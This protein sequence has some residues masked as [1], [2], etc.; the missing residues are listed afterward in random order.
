MIEYVEDKVAEARLVEG[1]SESFRNK[2]P[3]L[4]PVHL[5]SNK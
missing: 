2:L 1:V 3:C 4:R 5:I